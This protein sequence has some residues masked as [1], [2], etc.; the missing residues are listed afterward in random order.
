PCGPTT[1][2]CRAVDGTG[3]AAS[4]SFT[5]TVVC[6]GNQCP[7][8]VA[9]ASPN[10]QLSPNQTN[11]IVI[12]ANNSNACVTLDGSMSTDP[13]GDPLTYVWLADLDGDGVKEPLGSGA[14]LTYCFELG[15]Y[16]VMLMVDDGH[17]PTPV[18]ASLTVEVLSAGEAVELLI[19]KVNNA[20]L[21]RR[22]KR[23][24]IA[25]L[26]AAIAS[27]DRG[28]CVSGVNQL[29]AFQN[30]VRAQIGRENSALADEIIA[31]AQKILDSIDCQ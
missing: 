11:T 1:V 6:N 26:K 3:N 19:D 28:S 31:L 18:T 13:D 9:K 10:V 29:E 5:V 16:T 7:T 22:N 15:T 17:C 2:T 4:C 8:A 27:F 23:P 12:S 30:K 20:D 25:S 14:I 24:L 21:G